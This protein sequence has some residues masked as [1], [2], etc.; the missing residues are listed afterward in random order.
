MVYMDSGLMYRGVAYAFLKHHNEGVDR[1][2]EAFL[3]K[4]QLDVLSVDSVMKVYVDSVDVTSQLHTAQITEVSSDVA[5]IPNVRQWLFNIQREFSNQFGDDPGV[6][7]VGRD[8]GTVVFPDA[9][10]KFFLTASVNIRAQRRVE[11][12][13]FKG[14]HTTYQ[15]VHDAIV[16]RDHQDIHRD[17]APLKQAPDAIVINTD[18]LTPEGQA[19]III[20]KIREH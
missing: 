3:P 17:I 15:E 1:D 16:K 10:L 20:S 12:L 18:D 9:R 14:I 6:V 13:R 2:V 11:E 19:S 4:M 8:M 5:K 7:T